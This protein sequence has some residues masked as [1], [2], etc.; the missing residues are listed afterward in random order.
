MLHKDRTTPTTKIKTRHNLGVWLFMGVALVALTSCSLNTK[1]K[2]FV[3]DVVRHGH[4]ITDKSIQRYLTGQI[5]SSDQDIDSAVSQYNRA[6]DFCNV[7]RLYI[8]QFQ[9]RGLDNVSFI[10][11]ANTYAQLGNCS[12][13]LN[14][15][16]F[17][18]GE[19]YSEKA[20]PEF[21]RL[22]SKYDQ[23][24]Y[25]H[26]KFVKSVASHKNLRAFT[27][28]AGI[29]LAVSRMLEDPTVNDRLT[30]SYITQI[31]IPTDK[32]FSYTTNLEK[33][34]KLL[35]AVYNKQGRNTTKL[36]GTIKLIDEEIN[37]IR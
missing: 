25:S 2:Q 11:N 3:P 24:D 23:G 15:V 18:H 30:E 20:L 7:A 29:R 17:I 36:D 10:D 22:L 9:A 27:K 4:A 21:Y 12:T 13:E 8:L 34:Y 32:A 31:L 35:E 28:T 1:N 5:I 16:N 19:Q 37:Y 6:G 26:K 33:D 14:I